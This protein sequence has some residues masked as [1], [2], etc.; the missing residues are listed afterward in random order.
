M[1]VI[2]RSCAVKAASK[3]LAK[4]PGLIAGKL[5]TP[6]DGVGMRRGLLIMLAS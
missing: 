4:S 3:A 2:S 5:G 6:C 1:A